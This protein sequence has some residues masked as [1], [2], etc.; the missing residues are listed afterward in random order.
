MIIVFAPYPC[1]KNQK[2]GMI[3][4]V[5]Y[6][7]EIMS[8]SERIYINISL[9]RFFRKNVSIQGLVT[10]YELNLFIH[11]RMILHLFKLASVIYI[12]S[13]YNALSLIFFKTKARVIF[14]AHG[15]VPEE[16]IQLGHPLKSMIFAYAE[17]LV[18]R[19]CDTLVCVTRSMLAHFKNKYGDSITCEEIVL[20]ILPRIGSE[21]EYEKVLYST[22]EERSVIYAGG[23]QIWQN[24]DKMIAAAIKQPNFYYTFLSGDAERFQD[25]LKSIPITRGF[26]ESV[27]P[28][29]VKYYYLKNQFGFILRENNLVNEVACP[30]KLIEY[31]YWGVIPIVIN[32]KIGDFN[33]LNL[34]AVTLENFESGNIPDK[35]VCDN[36]RINNLST[37]K[38]IIQTSKH[39]LERLKNLLSI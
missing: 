36:M 35:I 11:Y 8:T 2:D 33:E 1:S 22:R 6:I 3:Q 34:S 23:T 16:L 29:Q 20:P 14:D 37:V 28:E 17:R 21:D 19:R 7:D 32:P 15:I 4:R 5:H 12:H 9:R 18:L 25:L 13:A 39:Q 30:T 38:E 24:V 27:V 26:C 10:N 31:I